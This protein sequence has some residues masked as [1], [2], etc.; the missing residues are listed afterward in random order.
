MVQISE[1]CCAL[2]DTQDTKQNTYHIIHP[3]MAMQHTGIV[4]FDRQVSKEHSCK[5][6]STNLSHA[7]IFLLMAQSCQ[8]STAFGE[9]ST[10]LPYVAQK[11]RTNF[12]IKNT[13]I[14]G[15]QKYVNTTISL[16][17]H[18]CQILLLHCYKCEMNG[19]K[20]FGYMFLT[21]AEMW[22]MKLEKSN[23]KTVRKHSVILNESSKC[24]CNVENHKEGSRSF[25]GKAYTQVQ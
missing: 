24:G 17:S 15:L 3:E 10:N 21:E 2:P 6:L 5:C 8:L 20:T 19:L 22:P 18:Q 4:R 25:F 14:S 16:S 1:Q 12:I 11:N 23:N 9:N 7:T 13:Y